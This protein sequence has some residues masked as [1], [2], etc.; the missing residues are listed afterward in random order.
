MNP[1]GG[2][3]RALL[4]AA[5]CAAAPLSRAKARVEALNAGKLEP[6]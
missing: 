1:R 6:H 2:F 5:S 4:R 3:I